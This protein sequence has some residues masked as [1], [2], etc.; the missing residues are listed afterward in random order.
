MGLRTDDR[1]I[2]VTQLTTDPTA[3]KIVNASG[4][5][6]YVK[7]MWFYNT[8][9]AERVVTIYIVPDSAGSQGT[10]ATA[11][12][13]YTVT[14]AAGKAQWEVFPYPVILKDT[15]DTIQIK[16]DSASKVNMA[17]YGVDE[18]L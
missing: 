8:D 14:I 9:T 5:K 12:M 11:N 18:V 4:H 1:L 7:G 2:D 13:H 10:A 6:T 15:N 16:A 17:A 3:V